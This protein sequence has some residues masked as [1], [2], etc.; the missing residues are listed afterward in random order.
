MDGKQ[1]RFKVSAKGIEYIL[2]SS[3]EG[4]KWK[5]IEFSNIVEFE[6]LT[7]T[8]VPSYRVVFSLNLKVK[9]NDKDKNKLNGINESEYNTF[10]KK[11]D[12]YFLK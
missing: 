11:L 9:L 3:M 4:D 5:L 10:R 8:K 7:E 2:N 12:A 1:Y 6:R